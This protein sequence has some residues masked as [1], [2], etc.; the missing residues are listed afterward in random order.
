M[1]TS[2]RHRKLFHALTDTNQTSDCHGLCDPACPYNCY[3]DYDFLTPPPPPPLSSQEHAMSPFLI[4]AVIIL[5][6]LI[7]AVCYYLIVVKSYSG[8]C[9]SRYERQS[10]ADQD[11]NAEEEFLDE[12]QVQHPIWFI[13]TIG[14]QQ[15][16]INSITIFQYRKGDRLIES[17]ECSVCLTEFQ[18]DETLRLLPKCNHAF[19][20]SCID[21]WLR[22][23]TNC[24]MCRA[25][26]VNDTPLVSG[27]QN[28]ENLNAANVG[29]QMENNNT[30]PVSSELS[31]AQQRNEHCE[32][33]I[34][35]EESTD[36]PKRDDSS[37]NE[38]GDS[39]VEENYI[40][41]MT[42]SLSMDSLTSA[43]LLR[44]MRN[45]H[46]PVKLEE[47]LVDPTETAGKTSSVID[48]KQHVRP[49]RQCLRTSPVSMK[50]SLS[51]GGRIF[52]SRQN[53]NRSCVLPH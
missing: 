33:T 4:V 6:S 27:P 8:W 39:L 53:R 46:N 26:I 24:P 23:H 2:M 17:T 19:H 15:S 25:H 45:Y 21:T 38:N 47:T 14:L 18:E 43:A 29:N 42:R 11:E 12:N 50:R 13:T 5:A 51:C 32:G 34:G 20:I 40:H 37:I 35:S 44:E 30:D 7:L 52:S 1:A 10:Q 22:S 31:N 48:S 49:A 41:P 16:V 28:S 3:S 9:G 36:I